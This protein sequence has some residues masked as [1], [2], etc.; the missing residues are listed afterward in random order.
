M[1]SYIYAKEP[2][3]H[4]VKAKANTMGTT[5][6][7]IKPQLAKRKA[8]TERASGHRT[9]KRK[10]MTERHQAIGPSERKARAVLTLRNAPD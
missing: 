10:A 8:M 3:I 6:L 1:L 5:P 2:S 4:S 9:T 7:A